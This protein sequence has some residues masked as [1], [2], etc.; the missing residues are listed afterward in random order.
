MSFFG[1]RKFTYKPARY[2]F[3]RRVRGS[4]KSRLASLKGKWT[5]KAERR[6]GLRFNC[7]KSVSEEALGTATGA[8]DS[9][10][11]KEKKKQREKEREEGQEE[12]ER[13]REREKTDKKTDTLANQT[14][15]NRIIS[16]FTNP[17]SQ[18]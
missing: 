10:R 8:C 12:Q 3:Q 13:K 2:V 1:H 4:I 14:S 11:E 16:N 9:E 6:M 5:V 17:P 15:V 18:I 7:K